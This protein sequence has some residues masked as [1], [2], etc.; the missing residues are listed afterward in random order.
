MYAVT[1]GVE[2]AWQA[3]LAHVADDA[4]VALPYTPWPAPN[5]LEKL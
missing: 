3:L 2:A 1:P 5:P 4:G